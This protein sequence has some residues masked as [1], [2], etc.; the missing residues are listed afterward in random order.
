[1]PRY[2]AGGCLEAHS[3]QPVNIFE[4]E[5]K[6]CT[7]EKNIEFQNVY[8]QAPPTEE[9]HMQQGKHTL[10]SQCISSFLFLT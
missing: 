10:I 2:F 7:L 6:F 1:M 3:I 4:I 8:K 9:L 5:Q